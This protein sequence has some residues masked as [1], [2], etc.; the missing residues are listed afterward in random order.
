M[1]ETEET[2]LAETADNFETVVT[3]SMVVIGSN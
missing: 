3:G 2:R 1:A